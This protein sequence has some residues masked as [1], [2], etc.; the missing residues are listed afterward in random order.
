MVVKVI[1]AQNENS[2]DNT[3]VASIIIM[4]RT[5]SPYSQHDDDMTVLRQAWMVF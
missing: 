5:T 1:I 2:H 4:I 3:G